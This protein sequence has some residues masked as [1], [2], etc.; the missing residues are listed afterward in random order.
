MKKRRTSPHQDQT[1][2]R[3]QEVIRRLQVLADQR[4]IKTISRLATA[5]CRE[6]LDQ[7]EYGITHGEQKPPSDQRG[8]VIA[9]EGEIV[10][11][12]KLE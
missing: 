11:R 5:L 4:G 6:R 8:K 3:D 9:A 2:I 10:V 12:V 1:S 7:L